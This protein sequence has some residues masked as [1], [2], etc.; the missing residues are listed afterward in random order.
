M[1]TKILL[2]LLLLLFLSDYS[3]SSSSLVK[4]LPPS[5][6]DKLISDYK[7]KSESTAGMTSLYYQVDQTYKFTINNSEFVVLPFTYIPNELGSWKKCVIRVLAMPGF[8]FKQDLDYGNDNIDEIP[9]DGILAFS[10][11]D[12]NSDKVN[13]IIAIYDFST[14]GN[15][16]MEPEVAV[17]T[18]NSV[19]NKFILNQALSFKAAGKRVRN[20]KDALKNLKR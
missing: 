14:S 18:Y 1:T 6:V 2:I 9:C 16:S 4:K 17:Y 5:V 19:S 13:E 15:K 12:V 7:Y 20:M 10:F 11:K 8:I 3:E